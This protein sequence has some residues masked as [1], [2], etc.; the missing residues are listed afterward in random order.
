[1]QAPQYCSGSLQQRRGKGNPDRGGKVPH[2]PKVRLKETSR[3]KGA[4]LSLRPS[5][6]PHLRPLRRQHLAS[7]YFLILPDTVITIRPQPPPRELCCSN[8]LHFASSR[9]FMAPCCN[10]GT[11]GEGG[12]SNVLL[13]VAL[14]GGERR[15][16]RAHTDW[17]DIWWSHMSGLIYGGTVRLVGYIGESSIGCSSP[18]CRPSSPLHPAN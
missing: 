6:P 13:T 9:R 8:N 10:L 14:S 3:D 15:A 7:L 5:L 16:R 4:S 2:A 1:M 12:S 17:S 18:F 11:P